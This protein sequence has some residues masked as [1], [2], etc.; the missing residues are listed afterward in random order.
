MKASR[1]CIFGM[2]EGVHVLR[3]KNI[4]LIVMASHRKNGFMKH[5]LDRVAARAMRGATCPL[6]PV[7]K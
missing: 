6:L 3:E 2:R 4:D 5:L 7:K 1:C